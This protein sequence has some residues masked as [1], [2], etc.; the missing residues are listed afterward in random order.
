MSKTIPKSSNTQ[1]SQVDMKNRLKLEC[2][3]AGRG[4]V[5]IFIRKEKGMAV[6]VLSS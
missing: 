1:L 4:P 5:T 6:L 3:G 2:L